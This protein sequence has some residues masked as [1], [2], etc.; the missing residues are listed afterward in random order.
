[1]SS[2]PS[3]QNLTPLSFSSNTDHQHWL[4]HYLIWDEHP[5]AVHS[6]IGSIEGLSSFSLALKY[7][8]Q[9]Y[10]L[11]LHYSQRRVGTRQYLNVNSCR[12]FNLNL[13][14]QLVLDINS[15]DTSNK[16]DKVPI[17]FSS[18]YH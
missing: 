7:T 2:V 1:M 3:V 6:F 11:K 16:F 14:L 4:C 8:M 9:F 10:T 18:R 17:L 13:F 12:F 15:H 5:V